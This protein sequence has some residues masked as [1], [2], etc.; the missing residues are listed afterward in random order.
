MAG[1]GHQIL[2]LRPQNTEAI[3]ELACRLGHP[4][5]VGMLLW[6]AVIL[7]RSRL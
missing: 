1:M 3:C 2:L 6:G 4:T 5:S 7:L